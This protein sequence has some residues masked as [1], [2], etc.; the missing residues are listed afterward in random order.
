MRPSAILSSAVVALVLSTSYAGCTYEPVARDS[1]PAPAA[2]PGPAR[3]ALS[4]PG[5]EVQVHRPRGAYD[6]VLEDVSAVRRA[7]HDRLVLRFAG[8]GRPGR[9][10]RFVDEAVL[11]GSGATVGLRGDT[12]LRLDISGTPTRMP[13]DHDPPV[14]RALGGAVV[15]LH[16]VGAFEGMTQVF[17][18][19]RGGRAPFRAF[20]LRAPSRLVVDLG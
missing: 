11:E 13:E 5:D 4:R 3:S 10:A 14:R 2:E 9:A 17:V 20:T 12:I 1:A 7:G 6:L 8:T 18:G 19:L 15:D 16:T